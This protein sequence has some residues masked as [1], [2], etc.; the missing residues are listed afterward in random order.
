MQSSLFSNIKWSP[1]AN[2]KHLNRILEHST[3]SAPGPRYSARL[4]SASHLSSLRRAIND[5]AP[6]VATSTIHILL[7]LAPT[8]SAMLQSQ[9]DSLLLLVRDATKACLRIK[10]SGRL[11]FFKTPRKFFHLFPEKK[12]YVQKGNLQLYDDVEAGKY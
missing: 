7:S 12:D 6:T 11:I 9:R 1:S 3:N 8:R 5:N 2:P 10:P 4:V